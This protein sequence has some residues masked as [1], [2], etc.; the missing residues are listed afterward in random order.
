MS[1]E[2]IH[3]LD[4][5]G[6]VIH[7]PLGTLTAGKPTRMIYDPM[8]GKW[9]ESFVDDY[10]API[11]RSRVGKTT[12]K[13]NGVK[14]QVRELPYTD[15]QYK[16]IA[17]ALDHLSNGGSAQESL[18]IIED[19]WKY[20]PGQPPLTWRTVVAWKNNQRRLRRKGLR[21]P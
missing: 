13:I 20:E 18:A 1:T 12:K 8:T 16:L 4:H 7:L 6:R 3:W 15:E 11:T 10:G 5:D 21:W 14:Y 17:K 2:L 19:D 9:W